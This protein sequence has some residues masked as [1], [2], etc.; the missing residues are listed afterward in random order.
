MPVLGALHRVALYSADGCENENENE[1]ESETGF[2]AAAGLAM[3]RSRLFCSVKRHPRLMEPDLS[4]MFQRRMCVILHFGHL[5]DAIACTCGW[6]PD[7]EAQPYPFQDCK[8][9][10]TLQRAE[11]H[12][13]ASERNISAV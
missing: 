4:G 3:M 13:R 2:C 7:R 11:K 1:N 6:A 10:R 9:S 8:A 12:S 5:D